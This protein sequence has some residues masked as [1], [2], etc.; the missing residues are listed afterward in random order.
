MLKEVAG[1]GGAA[2][3]IGGVGMA[4]PVE[5]DRWMEGGGRPSEDGP[6]L[7]GGG[8]PVVEG[9]RLP[10]PDNIGDGPDEGGGAALLPLAVLLGGAEA[11]GGGGVARAAVALPG[12][13]LLT[14]FFKSVS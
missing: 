2:N 7:P 3:P 10:G 12:S 13:F 5:T 4:A 6:G 11:R 1:R 8:I 9:G 14:H